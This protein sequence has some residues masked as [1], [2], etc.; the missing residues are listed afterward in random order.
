LVKGCDQLIQDLFVMPDC[1]AFHV[2]ENE[3][4]GIQLA[5]DP[6]EFEDKPIS[7]II[8]NTMANQGKALAWCTTEDAVDGPCSKTGSQPNFPSCKPLYGAGN[9]RS[10]GEVKLVY[11]T[12]HRVNFYSGSNIEASLFKAE[13][14][15]ACAREKVYSNRSAH[16]MLRL[17][18][19]KLQALGRFCQRKQMFQLRFLRPFLRTLSHHGL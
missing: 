13:A 14:H 2:F 6:D 9:D 8:K 11:R 1:Q 12:V 7:G 4:A 10:L 19:F 5:D 16:T 17:F 15:T 3:G 18:S